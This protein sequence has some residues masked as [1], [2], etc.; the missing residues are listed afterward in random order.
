MVKCNNQLN[1]FM[2][3]GIKQYRIKIRFQNMKIQNKK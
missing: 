1:R 3:N 2:I